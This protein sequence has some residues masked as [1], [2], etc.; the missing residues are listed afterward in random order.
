MKR[1]IVYL[2]LLG[3]LLAQLACGFSFGN[4]G[5]GATQPEP[6][7]AP[8]R[9]PATVTAPALPPAP[10]QP[11][12]ANP[13]EPVYISG[14]IPYT[15]PFFL[16]GASEP[17]VLLEDETGFIRRDLDF[18]FDLASQMIGP[19]I[20]DDQQK[21]T[22]ALPLPSVPRGILN[23]LDNNGQENTGVMVFAIAYW[24]NTWGGPFLEPRDGRG[25]SSASVSTVTDPERDYEISGGT[26]LIW[27]PD[28]EQAFPTDFGPDEKLFTADDP[29]AAVPAG[30]NLV[31]LDQRPFRVYKE[32][33]P[34]LT[35]MEGVTAVNDY[36]AMSYPEAFKALFEKASKE[37]P[38]TE[39]K[40][41]DWAALRERLYPLAEKANT[42]LEFYQALR[43]LALAIPDGHVGVTLNQE[44]FYMSYGG[45]FGL[46]LAELSDGPVV[47][48]QVLPDTPAAKA[49]IQPGAVISEWDGRPVGEAIAAVTPGFAPYSTQHALRHGQVTFLTRVPPNTSLE[50]RF[51]NTGQAAQTKTLQAVVEYDS[52]FKS[53]PAFNE[54]QLGLPVVSKM[55]PGEN[56]GYIRIGTFSDD[57]HLMAGLW[58]RAIQSAVDNEVPGLV[59]DLRSN[60]GG[61][62]S[63]AMDFAGFFFDQE[64]ELY[65]NEYF[66][67]IQ[68]GFK[69]NQYPTRIRPAPLQY[70]GKL[71]VLVSADCVSACESFAYAL[72][73]DGRATVLGHTPSAGAF[74]EVGQGQYKLP[75][76]LS[77]QF[78]TGRSVSPDGQLVLEGVGVVPDETVPLTL[79]AALG[80]VDAL[81]QRA[82]ELL[83][84]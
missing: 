22:Y 48:T 39:A 42:P 82:I 64:V 77:M 72:Q 73:H 7:A 68:G 67:E 20:I 69:P 66:N 18:E 2:A 10:V 35:L 14:D 23:D 4:L 27:A 79:E 46:V 62:G 58:E 21:L 6:T 65:R 28:G 50:V 78:P 33:S 59:I 81:L 26:L 13:D 8:T 83:T 3:V 51:Q 49:G 45:G 53:M 44:A 74:G 60:S 15:S 25:W 11:G 56:V 54:D 32:A 36:S 52:L 80:Q 17:F 16:Q 1:L 19:V 61:N 37:Y 47:V 75:D 71:V 29:T 70:T 9:P 55:L 12:A 38:F 76:D 31:D 43:E 84:R 63:L 30:Y 40:Q 5:G 34:R 57:Y 41:I 24:S